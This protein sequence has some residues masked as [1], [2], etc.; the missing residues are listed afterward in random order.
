MIRTRLLLIS[1]VTMIF[2]LSA[3]GT[4]TQG[5][6][7]V[8]QIDLNQPTAVIPSS[9]P[10]AGVMPILD[11]AVLVGIND[12]CHATYYTKRTPEEAI[13]AVNAL[14]KT[15]GYRMN[16]NSRQ[17]QSM[18]N[19]TNEAWVTSRTGRDLTF[20][21]A[22]YPVGYEFVNDWDPMQGTATD[23]VIQIVY[24]QYLNDAGDCTY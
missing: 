2:V 13:I 4:N 17:T 16:P 12:A 23:T 9:P 19:M 6:E 14:F 1:I 7:A 18:S 15:N 20:I 10:E 22:V 8:T 11:D 5:S 24:K 21:N 3:C